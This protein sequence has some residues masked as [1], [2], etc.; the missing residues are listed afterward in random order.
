MPVIIRIGK[1]NFRMKKIM[2]TEN[3]ELYTMFVL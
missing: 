3:M 2:F 1:V